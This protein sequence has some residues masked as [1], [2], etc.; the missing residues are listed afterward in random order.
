M[1][2]DSIREAVLRNLT[3]IAPDMDPAT[4]DP[5]IAFRDQFEFD[6]VDFLNF[7]VALEKDLG[8]KIPEL[9]FPKLASLDGCVRYLDALTAKG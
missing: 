1:T 9:D 2:D 8:V 7:A 4:L 3:E 6:S 5:G